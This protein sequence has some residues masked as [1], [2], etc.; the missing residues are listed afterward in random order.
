[1]KADKESLLSS[2]NDSGG[3]YLII[4][5]ASFPHY[6][7]ARATLDIDIFIEPTRE[8]AERA[9]NALK[10]FGF[11]LSDL[12]IDELLTKKVLIREYVVEIDVH[13]FVAGAQFYDAWARRKAGRFGRVDVFYASLD[14]LIAMKVAAGRPKDIED[15][16][17]L[18]LIKSST[19]KE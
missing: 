16:K 13:P 8:N 14:D 2:L 18:R 7:Y 15:L 4:G 10:G 17:A 12:S 5:A 19:P 11:D 9:W 3:R 6:G 1:M